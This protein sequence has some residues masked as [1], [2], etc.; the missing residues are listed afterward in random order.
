MSMHEPLHL[1]EPM[2][3]S[4]P[5]QR[6]SSNPVLNFLATYAIREVERGIGIVP[7]NLTITEQTYISPVK[8]E[9]VANNIGRVRKFMGKDSNQVVIVLPQR[10]SGYNPAQTIAAYLAT[11]GIIAYEVELPLRGHRLPF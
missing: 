3:I 1:S 8:T 6:V 4:Y 10:G 9:F 7:E 11:N 2:T 5:T